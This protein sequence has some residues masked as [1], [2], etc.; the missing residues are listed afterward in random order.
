MP[1]AALLVGIVLRLLIDPGG[2]SYYWCGLLAAAIMCDLLSNHDWPIAT[3]IAC[4]LTMDSFTTADPSVHAWIDTVGLLLCAGF[5]I[6]PEARRH[7]A[8]ARQSPELAGLP[9]R[10]VTSAVPSGR[11]DGT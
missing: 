5:A 7:D 1:W 4:L 2:Y 8:S 11:S 10:S 3:A 6:W 9:E